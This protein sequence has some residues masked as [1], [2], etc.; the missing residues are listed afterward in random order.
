MIASLAFAF[1]RAEHTPLFLA[2]MAA[3]LSQGQGLNTGAAEVRVKIAS[4]FRSHL[5]DLSLPLQA[6]KAQSHPVCYLKTVVSEITL[7]A[8]AFS[9][10][11][12]ATLRQCSAK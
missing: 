4:R 12:N 3:P 5:S 2:Y 6:K 7:W 8:R 9:R 11:S 10:I 1:W